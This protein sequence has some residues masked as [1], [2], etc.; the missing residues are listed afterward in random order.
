VALDGMV[1]RVTGKGRRTRIVPI[2]AK[3]VKALDRYLRARARH[4][5]ADSPALWLGLRGP[6]GDSGI[7]QMLRRRAR[8]AELPTSRVHP[9]A[10]RHG[11]A[12]AWLAGGGSEGGLMEITGWKTRDMLTRYAASTR[13]ERAIA[14]HRGRPRLGA[15]GPW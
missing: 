10:F 1:L 7:Q 2:G 4:A 15:T 6:M 12:H 8:E 3:T 13:G 9:H 14:E 11:F 5:L